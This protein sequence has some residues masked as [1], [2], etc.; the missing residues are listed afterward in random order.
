M[1]FLYPDMLWGL[2]A[3]AIPVAVHLFNFRRH[4]QVYFSNTEM[5]RVIQQENART[6]KIKY[7]VALCLRCLFIATLVLAFAFP[8]YQKDNLEFDAE[9]DLVG[10]YLDNSMSMKALSQRTT[11][12]EDARESAR[13]LVS[14]LNPSTR[15]VLLSNSYEIQNEYPMNQEEMLDQLDRMNQDGAS[16]AMGDVIDRFEMLRSQHGFSKATLFAYS[17]FQRS[18]FDLLSAV[19]DS[20]L[21][22][23]AL[24]MTS[25]CKSNIFV[26]SVWLASPIVQVGLPNE[27][28]ARVVSQGAK[29]VKGLPVSLFVD[30]KMA[31]STTIDIDKDGTSEISMQFV[32]DHEGSLRGVVSLDDHPI[33]FDDSYCFALNAN[34]ALSVVEIGEEPSPCTLLFDDDNQFDY[35]LM[36]SSGIDLELLSRAHLLIVN[37]TA[38]LNETMQQTLLDCVSEG[39]SLVLFPYKDSPNVNSFLCER[40]SAGMAEIDENQVAA[41]TV[42]LQHEFFEGMIADLPQYAD[43]PQMRKHVRINVPSMSTPLVT[44]QNGDVMLLE[45]SRGTGHVFLFSTCLDTSWSNLADNSLFVPVMLKIAML[46]GAVERIA[47]TLGGNK[48]LSFKDLDAYCNAN[49]VIRKE[50]GDFEMMAAVDRRPGRTLFYFNDD[51]PEAGFYDLLQ[52]DSVLKILAWN[53]DRI[54]S[55]MDFADEK[56]VKEG[57]EQAGINVSV[58]CDEMDLSSD[59]IIQA[60]SQQSSVWK[61]FVVVALLAVFAEVLVLRWWK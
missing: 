26:D 10:I 56:E 6:K 60:V 9:E 23:V 1:R 25:E 35:R 41:E 49:F 5:L 13:D 22:V 55:Q 7:L 4:K 48:V 39:A 12:F 33:T 3:L 34:P 58:V 53:N 31:A 43:L 42:A 51:L 28:K 32:A 37:E 45:V 54:E 36:K 18:S 21:K 27:I 8:Y 2:L 14:G 50:D 16:V 24:P 19:S 17:D 29:E 20:S 44:L 38:S 40:L 47:Y 61:W 30:D 46:G 11:L 52:N 59:S 57:F 15:F